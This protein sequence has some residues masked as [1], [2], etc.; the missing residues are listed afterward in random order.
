[1]AWSVL[2][3]T[4]VTLHDIVHFDVFLINHHICLARCFYGRQ[5][6]FFLGFLIQGF[7]DL[8]FSLFLSGFKFSEFFR[9]HVCVWV[10]YDPGVF[11]SHIP[12]PLIYFKIILS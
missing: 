4:H 11:M 6:S 7:S 12:Y 1:M 5:G 9:I 3:D 8:S 2:G 10:Y